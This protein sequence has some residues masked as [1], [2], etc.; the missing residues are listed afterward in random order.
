M[1]ERRVPEIVDKPTGRSDCLDRS[2]RT[3]FNFTLLYEPLG[4][5]GCQPPCNAG[6]FERMSKACAD[7]IVR[8]SGNTCA[9]SCNRFTGVENTDRSKSRSNCV[10]WSP[11][12][13][14][15][16]RRFGLS[17]VL[18]FIAMPRYRVCL[19]H[20]VT[21]EFTR[22]RAASQ[23]NRYHSFQTGP[24]RTPLLRDCSR[25]TPMWPRGLSC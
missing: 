14:V 25:Q 11:T 24:S 23:W 10:L 18:Q 22:T 8:F 2:I 13:V 19:Q 12:I 20:I 4:R 15:W 7:G 5:G 16:R 1:T 9:L 3:R 21:T 6:Y 17:K